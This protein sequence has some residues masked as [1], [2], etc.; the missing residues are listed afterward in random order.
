[1]TTERSLAARLTDPHAQMEREFIAEYLRCHLPNQRKL[2][3]L[4]PEAQRLVM[5]EASRYASTKLAEMETRARLVSAVHG[6]VPPH[7]LA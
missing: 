6:A 3:S 7:A 1:M 2:S 4:S 5:I